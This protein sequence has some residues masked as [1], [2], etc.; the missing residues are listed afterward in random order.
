MSYR[1]GYGERSSSKENEGKPASHPRDIGIWLFGGRRT[2]A[3]WG[4]GGL[5]EVRIRT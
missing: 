1:H 2:C 4:V 3:L 5:R